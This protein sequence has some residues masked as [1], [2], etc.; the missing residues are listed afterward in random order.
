M[1]KRIKF[2]YVTGQDKIYEL[3]KISLEANVIIAKCHEHNHNVKFKCE[4][5]EQEI[6]DENL[7][8]L[9]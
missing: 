1:A 9:D 3:I 7:I 5:L 8:I 6:V 2:L 4:D